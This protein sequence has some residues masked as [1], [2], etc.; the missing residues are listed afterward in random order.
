MT[1]EDAEKLNRWLGE[2]RKTLPIAASAPR[3]VG[4]QSVRSVL[5][6]RRRNHNDGPLDG[7]GVDEGPA[8]RVTTFEAITPCRPFSG[9]GSG[10]TVRK[11]LASAKTG[12]L[13][14]PKRPVIQ[15]VRCKPGLSIAVAAGTYVAE[16]GF[17]QDG[18]FQEEDA[19]S[20]WLALNDP[21]WKAAA[22]AK[23]ER[24][25]KRAIAKAERASKRAS[26]RSAS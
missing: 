21:I 26:A 24:A 18:Y 8:I 6:L 12:V 3:C 16:L 22:I 13:E 1:D 25:S 4:W 14:T 19:A 5:F 10:S 2:R 15:A 20:R 23:A 7:A 11:A 9:D 17:Y